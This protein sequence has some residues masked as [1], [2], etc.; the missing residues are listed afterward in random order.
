MDE[1]SPTLATLAKDDFMLK[2]TIEEALAWA[3]RDELPKA[4]APGRLKGPRLATP[5]W[6]KAAET[7]ASRIDVSNSF[8]LMPDMGASS[9]PHPAAVALHELLGC[10]DD[11]AFASEQME[12]FH[13]WM[14][15]AGA[16][17]R[18]LLGQ[19][20]A[21]ARER[22][23]MAL[24]EG[25][26]KPRGDLAARLRRCAL[27]GPPDGWEA[28]RRPQLR[29]V[30]SRQG[31]K[32]WFRIVQQPM[33][34]DA[35]GRAVEVIDVESDDGWC[36]RAKRPLKGAYL[37]TCLSPDP[38]ALADDRLEW[39]IW[40][41]A[42]DVVAEMAAEACFTFGGYERVTIEEM[43]LKILASHLP[44]RPWMTSEARVIRSR[45][46]PG[47]RQVAPGKSL[48]ANGFALRGPSRKSRLT[49]SLS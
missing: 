27:L 49:A 8:G 20:A 12:P 2:M 48:P 33:R 1:P 14:A 21:A 46:L 16:D 25:A 45:I 23:L 7:W 26:L 40:R 6:V 15:D 32:K 5:G 13:D 47:D 11:V 43:G 22:A 44:N 36:P 19:V 4:S 42:L 3:Y 35:R 17:E 28:A 34:F 18:D 10:L 31:Q 39:C 38:S 24:D 30:L 41:L 9:P 29:P 37:K